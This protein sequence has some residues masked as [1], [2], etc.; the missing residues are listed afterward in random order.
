MISQSENVFFEGGPA[1]GDLILNLLAGLTIIGIP[2]TFG[3]VVRALWLRFQITN[4]RISVTG[5]WLGKEKSQVS[6]SQ[7]VE[8]R[9]IPRGFGGWGDMVLVTRDG[10]KIEMRSLPN[11]REAEK[12]ILERI[13]TKTGLS[14]TAQDMKGF[15]A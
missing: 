11:F 13:A 14:N 15:A 8:V 10:S 3:A 4:K 7:I 5:G 1:K 9:S 12:Y 2:F 6:Y